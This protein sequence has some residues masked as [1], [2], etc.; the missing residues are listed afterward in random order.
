V[1]L[2]TASATCR[3]C[4]R[5]SPT[6]AT[7]GTRSSSSRSGTARSWSSTSAP[8]RA[9]TASRWTEEV[10]RRPQPPPRGLPR[11]PREVPRRAQAGLHRHRIDLVPM[12]TDQPYA[13]ALAQY[14]TLRMRR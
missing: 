12:V 10:P 2:S 5:R 4:C 14:L 1:I 13:E 7:R 6:C 11:Q 8:G 3:S 9:S